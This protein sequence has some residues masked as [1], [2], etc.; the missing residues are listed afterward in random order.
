MMSVYA[1]W[2]V[3]CFC[4]CLLLYPRAYD[5]LLLPTDTIHLGIERRRRAVKEGYGLGKLAFR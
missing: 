4:G 2:T 5:Q 1:I 3:L